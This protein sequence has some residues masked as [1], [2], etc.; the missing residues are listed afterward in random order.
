MKFLVPN[1]SCLQNPWIG[2]YRPQIPVLSVLCP[3]LNLLNPS[4]KNSWVRHCLTVSSRPGRLS[5]ACIE[6]HF[7][8]GRSWLCYGA[9]GVLRTFQ[10]VSMRLQ[11]NLDWLCFFKAIRNA[12]HRCKVKIGTH[13]YRYT[14]SWQCGRDL[15]PRNVS[16]IGYAV[17]LLACSVCCRYL[18]V[19][20]KGWYSCGLGKCGRATWHVTTVR[21]S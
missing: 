1:Y 14:V 13:L 10:P 17:T 2:G 20:P 18:A 9:L 6:M 11:I 5:L 12:F 3:Q 15:W 4:R 8:T 21:S 16:I 7:L 19:A